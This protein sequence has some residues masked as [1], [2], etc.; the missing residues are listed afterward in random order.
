MKNRDLAVALCNVYDSLCCSVLVDV[1]GRLRFK[2]DVPL[3]T[4]WESVAKKASELLVA[5]PTPNAKS[6]S[7]SKLSKRKNES[8]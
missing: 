4:I 6:K 2:R 1:D 5:S 8:M 3:Q 7:K